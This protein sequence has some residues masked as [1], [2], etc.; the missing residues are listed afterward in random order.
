MSVIP[1]TGYPGWYPCFES[2]ALKTKTELQMAAQ[3]NRNDLS[4][5]QNQ[6]LRVLVGR[7][8]SQSPCSIN[9]LCA[10]VDTKFTVDI[11]CMCLDR[12]H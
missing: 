9:R 4:L 1:R 8:D 11:A 12:M 2:K 3:L 7:K 5:Q 6:G 10:V